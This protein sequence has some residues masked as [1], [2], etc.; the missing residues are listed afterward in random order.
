MLL[1]RKVASVYNKVVSKKKKLIIVILCIPVV[2][3][4]GVLWYLYLQKYQ[5]VLN[6]RAR[7]LD[8][9]CIAVNPLITDTKVAYIGSMRSIIASDSAS[10][11]SAQY[12]WLGSAKEYLELE[13]Q[14]LHNAS[15]YLNRSDVSLFSDS[16]AREAMQSQIAI[17][18]TE[19][20][21]IQEIVADF[22]NK[23]NINLQDLHNKMLQ[24]EQEK[25]IAQ[26][27]YNLRWGQ[28]PGNVSFPSKFVKQPV[29]QCP[30]KNHTIPSIQ[31]GIEEATQEYF[32]PAPG[33]R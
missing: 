32:V 29:S 7:I 24:V 2:I 31:K 25:N 12:S 28:N 9:H 4:I 19:Y 15:A 18:G 17:Y 13:N 22:D 30:E 8:H 10:Y 6:E 33:S 3:L 14:W 21:G 20:K 27:A 23:E 1:L 26:Q 16:R 5:A 11:L